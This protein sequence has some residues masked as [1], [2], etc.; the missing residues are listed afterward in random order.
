M[1][2]TAQPEN[3]H[4]IAQI[5]RVLSSFQAIRP[6]LSRR[7][8][9]SLAVYLKHWSRLVQCE[10]PS[11]EDREEFE[12]VVEAIRELLEG[13]DVRRVEH[14]VA[15]NSPEAKKAA[16]WFAEVGQRIK[17]HRRR[18]GL[19]QTELAEKMGISQGALSRIERGL[20]AP[21]HVT[22]DNAARALNV[23]RSEIDPSCD[24]Q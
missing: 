8:R 13:V 4:E 14:L 19:R 17:E 11:E 24:A 16:R 2:T 20:L 9:R 10:D 1:K 18:A 5:V 3:Q 6:Q 23:P 21:T 7:K 12:E 15:P 22:I